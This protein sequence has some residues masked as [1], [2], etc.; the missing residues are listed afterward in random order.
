MCQPWSVCPHMY[1]I[2]NITLKEEGYSYLTSSCSGER[3]R[4]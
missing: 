4:V 1:K 2:K 3:I